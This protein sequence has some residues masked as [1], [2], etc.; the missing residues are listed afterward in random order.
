MLAR[1]TLLRRLSTTASSHNMLKVCA[2]NAARLDFDGRVNFDKLTS[3]AEL[4]RYETS[5]PAN[6]DEIVS[7]VEGC[8]ADVIINKEMP[9]SCELI[10]AL[11]K[12]VK[13]I[14]EAGTGF[15]NIQLSAAKRNG[16]TVCN[17]PTYSTEAMAH[18]AITLVLAQACS[19]VPQIRAL[20]RG[21]HTHFD[22]CH[23]GAWPHFEL[24]DKVIGL[25]GGLGKIGRRVAA[26][27]QAMGMHVLATSRT[28]PLGV[29][30]EHGME[31]TTLDDLLTRSDFVSIH[32]PLNEGTRGLIGEDGLRRMKPTA[33]LVNTSRGAII[34]EAAL[35]DVLKE[36]C[37]AGA[38]L[39]V[40]GEAAAPPPP[41]PPD[42]PLFHLDNVILTPHIGWQRLETRQRV[43]E[44][45]TKNII[46]FAEG[47]PI[48]Q[49]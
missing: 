1:L 32:C 12:S 16:I 27:A 15:N 4:T 19:L 47:A 13:L 44:Q 31:V 41:P 49:V 24:Q 46:A 10:D 5:D 20:A 17:I 29:G 6:L 35:V 39:D 38:G 11:P 23:L 3:V 28:A 30:A 21:D 9:M 34:D 26:I 42:H 8:S 7:R 25:V 33:F 48:N 22:R 18:M 45:V 36:G 2:L 37:I 43:I 40:L 14:C